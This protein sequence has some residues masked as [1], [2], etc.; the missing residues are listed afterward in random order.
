M[1]WITRSIRIGRTFLAQTISCARCHDHKFD[2][3]PTA[4]YYALAGIFRSTRTTSYD[5]PGVWSTINHVTLPPHETDA[6]EL[7]QRKEKLEGLRSKRQLLQSELTP[8][9]MKIP[10]ATDANVLT[11]EKPIAASEKDTRY[12][13]RFEAGPSVWAGAQQRTTDDDGLQID[14][15]RE[16]GS[17][18]SG[19]RHKPGPWSGTKD[20][21]KLKPA[22]FSYTGDGS[23]GIRIRLSSSNPGCGR[24]G[25]AIDTLSVSNGDRT[26]FSEDFDA[27]RRGSIEGT[28]ADTKLPVFAETT[29]PGWCRWRDQ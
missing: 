14:L 1:W 28:Q 24:F 17:V 7:T 6:A 18:L 27:L 13:V 25:G 15:L 19:F 3:V 5:G 23:G 4:D 9:V 21:Q 20:A 29:V 12:Q 10:G 22:E 8:L 26:I 2:P 16:D 11:L